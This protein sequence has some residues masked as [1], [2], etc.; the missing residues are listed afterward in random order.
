LSQFATYNGLW[1]KY[2]TWLQNN[3]DAAWSKRNALNVT[4]NDWTTT[5]PTPAYSQDASANNISPLDTRG[6]AGIWQFFPLPLDPTLVGDFELKNVNSGLSLTTNTA[7]DGTVAVVQRAFENAQEFLWTFVATNGGYYRIQNVGNGWFLTVKANSA[8]PGAL[9]IAAPLGTPAQGNEQWLPVMNSDKSYSFY[10]LSSIL[11]LDD[12]NAST[13][14]G[15]QVAQWFGNGTSGQEFQLISHE[16]ILAGGGEAGAASGGSNGTTGGAPSAG[17]NNGALAGG[18][19]LAGSSGAP[20]GGATAFPPIS[21]G[22]S[23][24]P[25]ASAGSSNG[26]S[27]TT[28][29]A[30]PS[31]LF[32]GAAAVFALA[33][34][35]TRRRK[36]ARACAL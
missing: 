5:T 23:G 21:A 16:A 19:A 33:A 3:A 6:A 9:I 27:C 11:A 14:P 1:S 15:T 35:G 2:Q 26:C 13:I 29:G 4:W 18:G 28:S 36:A 12:P 22:T 25:H 34:L 8:Q 31:D 20:N 17:G 24:D 7:G 32:G 10:N 30:P